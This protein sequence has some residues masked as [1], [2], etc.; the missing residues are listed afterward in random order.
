MIHQI[1]SLRGKP[2]KRIILRSAES[3]HLPSMNETHKLLLFMA[4]VL[5]LATLAPVAVLAG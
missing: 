3:G 2:L 5:L 4:A 1:E